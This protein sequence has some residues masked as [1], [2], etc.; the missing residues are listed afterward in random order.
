MKVLLDHNIPAGLGPLLAEHESHTTYSQGW[1]A[2]PDPQLL[3]RAR[4]AGY[5]LL[6][7]ADQNI[8]HQQNPETIQISV[9][10][11]S[12]NHWLSI[13]QQIDKI[14]RAILRCPAGAITEV[15]IPDIRRRP[16]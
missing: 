1:S 2:L 13:E 7:T 5:D 11:L 8:K 15:D 9:I 4:L 6:I 12:T 16:P 14:R 10:T 3:E